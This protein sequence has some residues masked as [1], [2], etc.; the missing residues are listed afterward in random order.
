[1][2]FYGWIIMIASLVIGMVSFGIRY[3]FGIFFKSL[4]QDFQLSRTA[5]SGLFSAYMVFGAMFAI[6]G[7]WALDKFGPRKV[8][9]IMGFLTGLSLIISSQAHSPWLLYLSFSLLLGAGTGALFSTTN[10]TTARWFVKR[11]GLAIGITTASGGM[12]QVFMAPLSTLLITHYDWRVS[13]VILGFI[14]LLTLLPAGY[15]LKRDPADFGLL[16]DGDKPE[17]NKVIR[18][19]PIASEEGY[20]LREAW[21]VR[22]FW[23]LAIIWLLTSISVH[24]LLTHL[25]PHAIDLGIPPLASAWII[26]F[27]GVGCI[28][29]R[30]LDGRLSDRVGR[31]PPAIL[32]AVLMFVLLLSLAFIK[33]LWGF[34]VFGLLVGYGWGG[35]GAVV[36]LLIADIFGIRSLG[37]ILATISLGWNFGAA[38]GPSFGGLVYDMTGSYSSAFVVAGLGMAVAAFFTIILR[39][40][41]EGTRPIGRERSFQP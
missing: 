16:P 2:L 9:M 13:F 25:P 35:M 27:I 33:Q 11:R 10:T 29:G 17:P 6:L 39:P 21:K 5:T 22:E 37:L 18:P 15:L 8:A 34:C 36:T 30:F 7:G 3:S 24:L 19:A 12:G 4:E 23:F 41:M 28:I 26:S 40:R 1:V 32:S 20:S 38:I 14:A 31:K